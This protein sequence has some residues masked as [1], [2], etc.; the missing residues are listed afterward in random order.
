MPRRI[1]ELTPKYLAEIPQDP[2]SGKPLLLTA[3]ETNIVIY[4][5]GLNLKD[6]RAKADDVAANYSDQVG[7]EIISE[8]LSRMEK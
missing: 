1:E 6:D 8:G 7:Y 4:S 3:S 2:F 5:V